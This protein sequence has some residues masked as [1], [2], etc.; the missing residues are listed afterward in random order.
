MAVARAT[1]PLPGATASRPR[2]GIR[3]SVC[4][5]YTVGM[6]PSP[7]GRTARGRF[8][9]GNPG[10]PGNPH[11]RRVAVLRE[12][13]MRSVTEDD[14]YV[15]AQALVSRAKDGEVPAVREL[16]DRVLGKGDDKGQESPPI[17]HVITGVPRADDEDDD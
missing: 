17:I 3:D 12:A 8:A 6:S 5:T 16:F 1:S 7:N 15:V 2:P 10:G 14:I 9:K 13:L 11:S 4:E